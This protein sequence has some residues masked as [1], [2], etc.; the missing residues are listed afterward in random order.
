MK[1]IIRYKGGAG[2]GNFGHAGRKGHVGGSASDTSVSHYG[3]S[4]YQP[5]A[6][7]HESVIRVTDLAKKSDFTSSAKRVP[8]EEYA[9]LK[10]SGD[11]IE[12][13]RV[14]GSQFNDPFTGD[15]RLSDGAY[16]SGIYTSVVGAHA[17]VTGGGSKYTAL[18]PSSEGKIINLSDLRKQEKKVENTLRSEQSEIVRTYGD[19]SDK[20]SKSVFS[21]MNEIDSIFN[22]PLR[23]DGWFA[24]ANGY[25]AID[26]GSPSYY[27][28]L[29]RSVLITS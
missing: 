4:G 9:K 3:A 2:S 11:Y 29:D 26:I 1:F 14:Q 17:M 25:Q 20:W 18:I 21:R 12:I 15:Y 8:R 5:H 13:Q 10:S 19:N 7:P 23:D 24:V 22:G 27:L 28:I 16:G 6:G